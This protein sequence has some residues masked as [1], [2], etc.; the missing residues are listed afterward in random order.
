[1]LRWAERGLF[2]TSGAVARRKR[3]V[4]APLDVAFGTD[5]S[6]QNLSEYIGAILAVMGQVM[7]GLSGQRLA[8][9]GDSVTALTWAVTERSRGDIVTNA[10]LFG[11][12]YLEGYFHAQSVAKG[13]R[14]IE[15]TALSPKG[16]RTVSGIEPNY[17]SKSRN[18]FQYLS[19]VHPVFWFNGRL[20][21]ALRPAAEKRQQVS[22]Y[23][24]LR[25]G[26][27]KTSLLL[28]RCEEIDRMKREP[29][30]LIGRAC[31]WVSMRS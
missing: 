27:R 15:R 8:L 26:R 25:S 21:S 23:L 4:S 6:Y 28:A 7:L 24:Q 20:H 10:A 18:Y 11:F 9:R 12:T 16:Q 29:C 14:T 17:Y 22:F 5:S 13:D 31:V 1:M 2:G 30:Y 3:W 19:R